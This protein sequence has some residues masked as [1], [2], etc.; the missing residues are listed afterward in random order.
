MVS[1]P[2][3][4]VAP[5]ADRTSKVKA[6]ETIHSPKEKKS[7]VDEYMYGIF[8]EM[9]CR[10]EDLNQLHP[11]LEA[12]SQKSEFGDIAKLLR[13]QPALPS[14]KVEE[15]LLLRAICLASVGDGKAARTCVQNSLIIKYTRN[16]GGVNNI[17]LFF[18]K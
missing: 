16:L 11:Q 9:E 15:I 1:K 8:E 4:T 18:G 6:I 13:Q 2:E 17:D 12:Y 3:D 7:V 5:A 10:A 14:E